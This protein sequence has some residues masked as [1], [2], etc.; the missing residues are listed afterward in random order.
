MLAIR[1]WQQS[2][3]VTNRGVTQV[4]ELWVQESKSYEA[5]TKVGNTDQPGGVSH[6]PV[7]PALPAAREELLSCCR[8][9]GSLQNANACTLHTHTHKKKWK[10]KSPFRN[11]T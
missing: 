8:S 3:A 1:T 10:I 7:L 6:P 4:T 11:D 2:E 9:T 5:Q